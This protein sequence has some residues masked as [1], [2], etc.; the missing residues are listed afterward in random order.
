MTR[1][2]YIFCNYNSKELNVSETFRR[3]VGGLIVNANAV[4]FTKRYEGDWY[5]ISEDDCDKSFF[6]KKCYVSSLKFHGDCKKYRLPHSKRK[7]YYF[8]EEDFELSVH[9][10]LAYY[11]NELTVKDSNIL[12]FPFFSLD[13]LSCFYDNFREKCYET[14]WVKLGDADAVLKQIDILR[15]NAEMK[16]L[17]EL[18]SYIPYVD[19][20]I[21]SIGKQIYAS[22]KEM[23]EIFALDTWPKSKLIE[24][25]EKCKLLKEWKDTLSREVFRNVL[26]YL[27]DFIG[28]L[29]SIKSIGDEMESIEDKEERRKK[30]ESCNEAY[31]KLR[32]SE[33]YTQIQDERKGSQS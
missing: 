21:Y 12:Y 5:K 4:S 22:I 13:F 27:D 25:L 33:F 23:E 29:N 20:K 32:E 1:E 2:F 14:A 30:E 31:K 28:I 19:P 9:H 26:D 10:P 24:M 11:T 6:G 3:A 18:R 8:K 15:T 16:V 17:D 7:P